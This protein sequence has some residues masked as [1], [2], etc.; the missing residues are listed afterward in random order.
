VESVSSIE[1]AKKKFIEILSRKNC[2]NAFILSS[3]KGSGKAKFVND[4][5]K[6]VLGSEGLYRA[7]V[8]WIESNKDKI[9]INQVREIYDFLSKTSYNQM[10]RVI[11]LDSADHLNIQSSNAL[12]KIL[13]DCNSNSYFI[14]ISH[15]PSSILKTVRSRCISIKMPINNDLESEGDSAYL[16]L[17][18]GLQSSAK[19]LAEIE[20]LEF[21]YEILGVVQMFHSDAQVLNKFT[22][23]YFTKDAADTKWPLFVMLM[24][25][26]MSKLLKFKMCEPSRIIE[27]EF[28]VLERTYGLRTTEEWNKVLHEVRT[29][30]HQAELCSLSVYNVVFITF[31]KIMSEKNV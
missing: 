31:F 1:D 2:S 18:N 24:E 14:L 25:H 3:P 8:L 22:D 20:A 10:P 4:V 17:A 30:L 21:Y 5:I 6:Q 12:L 7:N 27:Q 19:A 23:K 15:N 16:Y 11:V 28:L 9:L 29:P 26:F 13:E